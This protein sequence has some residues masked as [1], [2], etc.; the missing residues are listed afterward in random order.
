MK[1]LWIILLILLIFVVFNPSNESYISYIE[2]KMISTG[3][4]TF[5]QITFLPAY[6]K[7][8]STIDN[9]LIFKVAVLEDF[10]FRRVFI[11]VLGQWI[12]W[13]EEVIVDEK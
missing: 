12:Y 3:N 8:V 1:V 6:I 7:S 10:D 9:Y 5:L 2:Q 13:H 4:I 11:G